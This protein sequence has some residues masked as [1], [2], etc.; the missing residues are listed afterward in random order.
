MADSEFKSVLAP[1]LSGRSKG[2]KEKVMIQKL[3]VVLAPFLSGRSK[4][5]FRPR[6]YPGWYHPV[7][8]PFL[9]GR[10]KGAAGSGGV[11]GRALV[12]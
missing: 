8:A 7:L 5:V 9:S 2:G 1:F 10:S 3:P 4:G 12:F 6:G 11:V